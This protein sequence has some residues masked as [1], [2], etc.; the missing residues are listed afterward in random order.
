MTIDRDAEARTGVTKPFRPHGHVVHEIRQKEL[1]LRQPGGG[2]K[3][4]DLCLITLSEAASKRCCQLAS[5]P[6]KHIEQRTDHRGEISAIPRG[7][8]TPHPLPCMLLG[9]LLYVGQKA[10]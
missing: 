10:G 3:P 6:T 4:A 7:N 8:L 2:G 9:H 5:H 1:A